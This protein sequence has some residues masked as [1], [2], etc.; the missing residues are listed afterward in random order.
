MSLLST[1]KAA[2]MSVRVREQVMLEQP[3]ALA[4]LPSQ[5]LTSSRCHKACM[6]THSKCST[7]KVFLSRITPNITITP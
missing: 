7:G 6:V 5:G 3:L 4:M 2:D 1:V